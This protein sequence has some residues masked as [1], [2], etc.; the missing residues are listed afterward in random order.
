MLIAESDVFWKSPS[1]YDVA[2][3]VGLFLGIGSIWLALALA[4][5]Q[6]Q[7]DLKKATDS[8]IVAIQQEL[9]SRE[10]AEGIRYLREANADLRNRKWEWGLLRLEEALT[11]VARMSQNQKLA[12]AERNAMSRCTLDLSDI[13]LL[14]KKHK[15]S[16]KNRGHLPAEELRPIGKVLL[17]LERFRSRNSIA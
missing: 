9:L 10:L 11:V 2:G 7:A 14:V 3:L 4:K 15:H 12:E 17:E 16:I 13:V 8:A 5:K 6:L 1:V